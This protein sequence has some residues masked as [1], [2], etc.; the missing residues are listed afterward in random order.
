[1]GTR[2]KAAGVSFSGV[3]EEEVEDALKGAAQISMGTEISQ[4]DLD[5]IMALCDQVRA[6]LGLQAWGLGVVWAED[7]GSGRVFLDP[8]LRRSAADTAHQQRGPHLFVLPATSVRFYT[9]KASELLVL[10]GHLTLIL[11]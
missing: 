10:C 9:V 6:G 8:N 7:M 1:M 4:E 11:L 2:D 3:L 5:N